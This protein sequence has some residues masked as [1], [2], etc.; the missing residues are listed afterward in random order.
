MRPKDSDTLFQFGNTLAPGVIYD[1]DLIGIGAWDEQS[2]QRLATTGVEERLDDPRHTG[3]TA[4][5]DPA[6]ASRQSCSSHEQSSQGKMDRAFG[7]CEPSRW[8][9]RVGFGDQH[10]SQGHQALR[11]GSQARL[12]EGH[13]PKRRRRVAGSTPAISLAPPSRGVAQSGEASPRPR[14]ARGRPRGRHGS[15]P[16]WAADDVTVPVFRDPGVGLTNWT[17]ALGGM[18]PLSA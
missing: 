15:A 13:Q 1:E 12:G 5:G 11:D 18:G 16:C 10:R 2:R 4:W 6:A 8:A 14:K 17:L 3:A 9:Y 7:L